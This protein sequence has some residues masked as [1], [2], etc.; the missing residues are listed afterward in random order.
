[1]VDCLF[2]F[3][4]QFYHNDIMIELE[5]TEEH[6]AL[7]NTVREFCAGEVAPYIKEWDEK[8]HFERRVFDKMAE[9]GLLGVCIPEQYGGAGFDY[10][11]LGLVCEDL[12]ACDTFLRVA[13]SV[14]V[15]L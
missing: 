1:M 2:E 6:I 13:M 8:S 12:E 4:R 3:S 10:I 15:G 9:L 14:H 5:L 11:S 7:Q